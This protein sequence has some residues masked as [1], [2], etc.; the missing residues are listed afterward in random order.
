MEWKFIITDQ[1]NFAQFRF[2]SR[3]AFVAR[4]DIAIRIYLKI[5]LSYDDEEDDCGDDDDCDNDD[6]DN[7]DCDIYIMMK[8]L[9]VCV[10]RK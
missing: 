8:C 5:N 9:S 10:S 4:K 3:D 1:F 6:C 2:Y 7:D